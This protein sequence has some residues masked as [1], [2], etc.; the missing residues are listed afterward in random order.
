M[1]ESFVSECVA[2]LSRTPATLDALLRGLPDSWITATEGPG[3][4]CPYAVMGH[5]IHGELTDWIPRLE[6][7]LEHGPGEPFP[8]FDRLAQFRDAGDLSLADLLDSFSRLRASNLKRLDAFELDSR[9][10][11]L[12][13]TH[14][15]F[16]AVTAR[17]LIAT[18][19][20][21]DLGH[22]VQV[23]RVM[24]KRLRIEVGPW[25]AYLSV[26]R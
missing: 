20:A 1:T 26:M 4:W 11:L 7:I 13:G 15:E 25:A 10:L 12:T 22:L 23:N 6:I 9:R 5:L 21:H 14:P 16:G 3:T 2:V 8:V 24:A 18:W 19:A 17:Q